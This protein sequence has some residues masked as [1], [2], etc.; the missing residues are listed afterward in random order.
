MKTSIKSTL[1]A[2]LG[3]LALLS[4]LSINPAFAGDRD[5]R[6]ADTGSVSGWKLGPG[7]E[8]GGYRIYRETGYGWQQVSGS[9]TQIGGTS[10]NPWIVNSRNR[11]YYW[12]GHDWDRMPGKGVAIADGWVLGTKHEHGG[13]AI[14]RWNG[15]DWDQAPGGAI[16]I[17]GSYNRPWV[18]NDRN[19]RFVW[20]GYD[21]DR[22]GN[23]RRDNSGYQTSFGSQQPRYQSRN[24]ER[25]NRYNQRSERRGGHDW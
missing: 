22:S 21:W 25:N 14:Y 15:Y 19:Q 10:R 18:I 12:N 17:G 24:N 4:A 7:R 3:M 9:A 6:Y 13:Y 2:A 20:N 23:A 16:S 1:T 5:H 11:I 8:H